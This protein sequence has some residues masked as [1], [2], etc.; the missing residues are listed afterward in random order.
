MI[1]I[2]IGASKRGIKFILGIE[3]KGFG[4]MLNKRLALWAVIKFFFKSVYYFL[5]RKTVQLLTTLVL[6]GPSQGFELN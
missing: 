1:N 4:T 3:V 2:S 5:I 6:T